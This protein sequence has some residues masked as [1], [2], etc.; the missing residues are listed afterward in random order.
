MRP[1]FK[2]FS[3]VPSLEAV[4]QPDVAA[5]FKFDES[6]GAAVDA[7][8]AANNLGATG[9][10]GSALSLFDAAADG[11]RTFDGSTTHFH[12]AVA[13]DWGDWSDLEE[14]SVSLIFSPDVV[15]GTQTLFHVGGGTTVNRPRI[16]LLNTG[17]IRVSHPSSGSVQEACGVTAGGTYLLLASFRKVSALDYRAEIFCV[18]LE[19]RDAEIFY[20]ESS[21][22]TFA[23]K[24]TGSS[25]EITVGARC[26]TASTTF[27]QFFDG[28][29][30]DLCLWNSRLGMGAF[31]EL[32]LNYSSRFDEDDLYDR[33]NYTVHLKVEVEDE[34]GAMQDLTNIEGQDYLVS[35]EYGKD[36]DTVTSDA[37]VTVRRQF[38]KKN[39]APWM[40]GSPL[41][42]TSE[43]LIDL[44]REVRALVAV[45]P[46]DTQPTNR[47]FLEQWRGFVDAIAWGEETMDVKCRGQYSALDDNFIESDGE[48]AYGSDVGVDAE[49]VMQSIIN[50]NDPHA[51]DTSTY[52]RGERVP[53]IYTP[54]TP[55]FG[56][57]PFSQKMEPTG[58]ALQVIND[59]NGYRLAYD[60]DA[61]TRQD[62]LT[63]QTPDRAASTPDR[64]FTDDDYLAVE[65]IAIN[66]DM[67]RNVVE[68]G[69]H[70][71]TGV[72]TN[73]DPR[74]YYTRT[75]TTSIGKYGR[76]F[77][78]IGEGNTSL[79]NSQGEAEALA[80]AVVDD[81]ALPEAEMQIVLPFFRQVEI[82]DFYRFSS[83]GVHFDSNLDL[84][85]YGFTHTF[86]E[87]GEVTTSLMLRGRPASKVRGWRDQIVMPGMQP[88][89]P[90]L[91]PANPTAAPTASVTNGG[92]ARVE[93]ERPLGRRNRFY[94]TT[95]IHASTSGSFSSGSSTLKMVTRGDSAELALP[96]GDTYYFRVVHR[97][98]FGN[99]TGE[100]PISSSLLLRRLIRRPRISCVKGDNSGANDQ[101]LSTDSTEYVVAWPS[102]DVSAYVL[103]RKTGDY[104]QLVANTAARY[105]VNA[106]LR[107]TWT[108]GTATEF[109]ARA[110]WE[111][112]TDGGST[113]GKGP[114]VEERRIDTGRTEIKMPIPG[115]QMDAPSGSDVRVRLV[116]QWTDSGGSVSNVTLM[117]NDDAGDEPGC[118][119][120]IVMTDQD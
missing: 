111:A 102:A 67:I 74:T 103:Q 120:T 110:W 36:L 54:T 112:S 41:Y 100:S 90:G 35:F 71:G 108:W 95:E 8:T 87:S 66:L 18:D 40:T 69:V 13:G 85:V 83:N 14:L 22:L 47:D 56:I 109:I 27:D 4:D 11:S 58:T 119:M 72:E 77:A 59:L 104:I 57:H 106:Y 46:A 9:S 116:A 78:R 70:N 64:T 28:T 6:T 2:S 23:S 93:W 76:L 94:D 51:R 98:I 82:N 96:P 29:M 79:L 55:N 75:D 52:Y 44:T 88:T 63:Y 115:F 92:L 30:D 12:N 25:N 60:F 39:L 61:T 45:V 91:A 81:L 33:G 20:K 38:Y 31:R 117:E 24:S 10:P 118:S 17:E 16:D 50:D 5:Y 89:I 105:Q 34:N 99:R 114:R 113:W 97:D 42:G 101:A 86:D 1:A 80:Q 62:R 32:A 65:T 84:A 53:Q 19:D 73:D 7:T 3:S 43:A 68:V 48:L 15:S 107:W 37:T 49:T 26:V 21:D